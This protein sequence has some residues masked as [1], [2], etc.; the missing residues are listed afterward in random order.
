MKLYMGAISKSYP[1][2][3]KFSKG[4]S[5]LYLIYFPEYC[6]YRVH[7][8]AAKDKNNKSDEQYIWLA[9]ATSEPIS[10]KFGILIFRANLVVCAKFHTIWA[11]TP[12]VHNKR[13]IGRRYVWELYLNCYRLSPISIGFVLGPNK[14]CLENFISIG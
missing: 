13:Q 5:E 2:P 11:T 7:F 8:T 4:I 6:C 9:I 10:I 1:I 12:L 14:C 3:I